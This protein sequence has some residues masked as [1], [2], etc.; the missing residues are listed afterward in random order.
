MVPVMARAMLERLRWVL[1]LQRKPLST[2][3]TWWVVPRHSR[4]RMV[5]VRGS[6]LVR[7]LGRVGRVVTKHT[8]QQPVEFLGDRSGEPAVAPF[9]PRICNSERKNISSQ[10]RRCLA[11]KFSL[12]E[13]A[14]FSTRLLLQV[15]DLDT[16]ISDRDALVPRFYGWAASPLTRVSA[17]AER[18][19]RFGD[20]ALGHGLPSGRLAAALALACGILDRDA[21]D[22]LGA[23]LLGHEREAELLAHHACKEPAN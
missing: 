11:G 4:T 18:R 13:Y 6:G 10:R 23:G 2:T 9:L 1:P 15:V 20:R 12:P 7:R 17:R 21:V 19:D 3:A 22:P 16:H 5:P 8:C 14:Q